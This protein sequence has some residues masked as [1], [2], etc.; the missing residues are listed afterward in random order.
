MYINNLLIDRA[1]MDFR[2]CDTVNKRNEAVSDM[3]A[4][5]Y[6]QNFDKAFIAHQK[7]TFCLTAGSKANDIISEEDFIT[8]ALAE[9]L[10]KELQDGSKIKNAIER[11]CR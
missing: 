4:Y 10:K 3:I 8:L 9:E 7:P 1:E 5:L 6:K 2:F 11:L